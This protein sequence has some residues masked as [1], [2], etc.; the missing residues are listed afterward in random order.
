MNVGTASAT[1][2]LTADEIVVETALGGLRYCLGSF[3]QS[4][5][6]A[7]TGAGGMDTGS[8]PTSG[9]VAIYAIYNPTGNTRAL[10][11]VNASS[12][13]APSIYGGSNMPAGYTASALVSVWPTTSGGLLGLANQTDRVIETQAITAL[14]TTTQYSSYTSV[15]TGTSIPF[16]A[17]TIFGTL[18][19]G[20]AGTSGGT[21]NIASTANGVGSVTFS[22]N[23]TS[24]G[25]TPFLLSLQAART[26]FINNVSAQGGATFSVSISSYAF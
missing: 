9:Y 2:T 16:N 22:Q 14:N 11:A 25:A 5:N 12:T 17:R 7:T 26:F 15:S 13:A 21:I 19:I 20:S 10:M 18:A 6:L 1:A 8:A 23:T 4:I 3:N 24:G